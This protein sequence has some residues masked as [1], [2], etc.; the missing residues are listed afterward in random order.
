MVR[1]SGERYTWS[2][3]DMTD[4]ASD[5][6]GCI[7]AVLDRGDVERL[8]IKYLCDT[9]HNLIKE[10]HPLQQDAPCGFE[11]LY[12][13]CDFCTKTDR[14]IREIDGCGVGAE[15]VER[16]GRCSDGVCSLMIVCINVPM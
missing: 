6:Y 5:V 11:C 2:A 14:Q 7:Y 9:G 10:L 3:A 15:R 4:Q 16:S 13:G 12:L 1:T 8:G